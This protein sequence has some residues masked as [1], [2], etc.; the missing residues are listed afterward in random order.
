MLKDSPV[1]GSVAPLSFQQLAVVDQRQAS[2]YGNVLGHLGGDI[3]ST[4]GVA[5]GDKLKLF[6]FSKY[7]NVSELLQKHVSS[8]KIVQYDDHFLETNKQFASH[9]H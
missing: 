5:G 4:V 7:G 2:H 1:V 8:L 6:I 9:S 3:S